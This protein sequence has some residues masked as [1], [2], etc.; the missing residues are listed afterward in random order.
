VSETDDCRNIEYCYNVTN[1][2]KQMYLEKNISK[3]QFTL[4][5][6]IPIKCSLIW[7]LMRQQ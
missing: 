2:Y 7:K 6:T 3:C 5:T 1:R 4:S